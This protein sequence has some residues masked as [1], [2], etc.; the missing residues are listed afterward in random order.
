MLLTEISNYMKLFLQK[1]I[2]HIFGNS[3]S[4]VPTLSVDHVLCGLLRLNFAHFN[5][6]C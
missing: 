4:I 1:P 5:G 3:P 6:T 2:T